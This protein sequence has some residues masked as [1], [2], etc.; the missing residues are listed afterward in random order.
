[1]LMQLL[2]VS[3]LRGALWRQW[4][5]YNIY[6]IVRVEGCGVLV[7]VRKAEE[8]SEPVMFSKTCLTKASSSDWD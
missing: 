8:R 4:G 7:H 6:N 2:G 5:V 3:L 1:M